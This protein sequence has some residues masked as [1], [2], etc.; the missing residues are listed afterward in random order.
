MRE[1][2]GA[3]RPQLNTVQGSIGADL[4]DHKVMRQQRCERAHDKDIDVHVHAA[5]IAQHLERDSSV[6]S[7]TISR[8]PLIPIS[9]TL[10]AISRTLIAPYMQLSVALH[11]YQ[12]SC[13]TRLLTIMRSTSARWATSSTG[14][15]SSVVTG[16]TRISRT[17]LF[18][19][20][21]HTF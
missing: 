18:E 17:I 3:H 13:S 10:N 14:V 4:P 19:R 11:D 7:N 20:S 5:E 6:P 8:V 21:H 15:P 16:S 1:H 2:V 9:R 12:Y